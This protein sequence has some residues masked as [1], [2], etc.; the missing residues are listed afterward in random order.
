MKLKEKEQRRAAKAFA[1]YWGKFD[2]I[3][4]KQNT[5]NFWN[6]LLKN[7]YG[8]EN[9]E[10]VVEYEKPVKKS[11]T[12]FIDAYL[13]ASRVLIEQKSSDVDLTKRAKQSNGEALT[14]YEQ[15]KQYNDRLPY[16]ER[17]RWIIMSNFKEF[18]I[19]DMNNPYGTP[20]IIKLSE[21]PKEC[22]RMNF[23][24]NETDAHVRREQELSVQAG[25]I[26][27]KLYAAL[28][29]EYKDPDAPKSLESMNMLCV[30][31]V[32]CLYAED[33]GLFGARNAFFTY[34]SAFRDNPAVFRDQLIQFFDVLNTPEDQRDPYLDDALAAFPYV[35]GGL[36]ADTHIEIP[37]F[38]AEIIGLILDDASSGFNWADISP[39]IFGA[40]FESTL[41]P[42]TRRSGGM[43]Y[44][45]LENIHKVIDPL[46]LDELREEFLGLREIKVKKKKLNA[47]FAFQQKLAALTFLDPACGS[48]NFLTE[49]YLSLR[50]LENDA[51]RERA[52]AE[53]VS[54]QTL[55][56]ADNSNPVMV[57]LAQLYGIE[58]ND[59]AVSVART[60]LWIAEHQMLRETE[61]IIHRDIDF[62]PLKSFT[63]IVEGNALRMDWN[64]VVPNTALSY[65]MGNPPF[66]GS[67][68]QTASQKKDLTCVYLNERGKTYPS[69]GKLDY[70]AGWYFKAAQYIF[71][72]NIKVA[73]V[74]TNS[75][76]QGEL[77]SIIWKPIFERFH[78]QIIFAYQTFVW[79]NEANG[80]AHVH[81][82]IIG[83]C[84]QSK[85]F[86]AYLY[87]QNS[88]K[89]VTNINAY[90]MDSP[91]IFIESR[92]KPLCEVPKMIRGNQ[93]TDGGNLI[94][95]AEDLK[96]FLEKEPLARPYIKKL[97]GSKEFLHNLNRWCLWLVDVS[98]AEINKMPLVKRRVEQV[99]EMRLKSSF[100][101]TRKL[102][103]RPTLFRE[104][105]NPKSFLVIPRVSSEQ[106]RYIPL[107]YFGK[108]V[109]STDSNHII[110]NATLYNFG[111]LTSNVHNAW[112]R[113]V[114]GR[115]K[116][117]YRYSKNIVYNNF[118]WPTPTQKQKAAI[119]KTAQH[120]LDVRKKY[121]DS[122]LADLYNELTMPQDLRAAHTA[123][124]KA[125]MDAYGFNYKG[126]NKMTEADCVAALMKRYEKLSA[127]KPKTHN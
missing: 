86:P 3:G 40:V 105:N 120:I 8:L 12:G 52:A 77:V 36:F 79:N 6:D 103:D 97:I 55:M 29:K 98:P 104:T 110:P 75:V 76:T 4:E 82:V 102:A 84:Y 57:S 48:G 58:I 60:A 32:F 54:G 116:S 24:M 15:A 31:L 38:N 88:F 122:S 95:E 90:L 66:V 108:D 71:K 92:T 26:V 22:Y 5:Q 28:Q 18:R 30:R 35:N 111:V 2:Y 63:N 112:M 41:N 96:N 123:N 46:F 1:E 11:T 101:P 67:S 34:M 45:S 72:T 127:P 51:L 115:L 25:E 118:P 59:F 33:A 117:D 69:V 113:A 87:T 74:S 89:K 27:G 70:V 125:V 91:N 119:E 50:R 124:D 13:P 85:I 16:D 94:I 61:E 10:R 42:E 83:F 20:E 44:T 78:I 93:P 47:L 65:I 49:T 37:R 64:A 109:I 23:L 107:G 7:V 68:F 56:F 106:R 43:H 39:T 9:P 81:C 126:R 53:G 62:L 21:L 17:A 73:F 121:P 14:P 99:R 80:K 114:A 100:E 19:H